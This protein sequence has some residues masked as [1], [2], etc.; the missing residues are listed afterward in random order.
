MFRL[1][2]FLTVLLWLAA[3]ALAE[4]GFLG[5]GGDVYR[6][7]QTATHDTGEADDL[8]IAGETVR[9]SAPVT[10]TA[11]VAGRWLTLKGTIGGDLYA[12][13][14][15]IRVEAPV[16][17][18]ATVA[19][20]DVT[21]GEIGGDL[22]ASGSKLALDGPVGGYALLAGEDL[23][24]GGPIGGDVHIMAR[25]VAF[26][27]DA[28][29]D[30]RLVLYEADP[31]ELEVPDH[32]APADRIERRSLSEWESELG[33]IRPPG[34][35]EIIARYLM[36]IVVVAGIAALV[37]AL[38][39]KKLADIRAQLL[40]HPARSLWYGFLSQST[41][42]GAMVVLAVSVV[43]LLVAPAMAV[44]AGLTAFAGYILGAYAFGVALLQTVGRPLPAQWS[45]RAIAGALGAAVA[46]LVALIPFVGWLFVIALTLAGVGAAVLYFL[47][48]RF[49]A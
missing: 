23:R 21:L 27:P 4:A 47:R 17:G 6:A 37:A 29:V 22:R 38:A 8:F 46:C 32:V 13:G 45:E 9:A 28:K 1:S 26:G 12:A 7:A 39:P 16:E 34:I 42:I 2:V 15:T 10:G 33:A 35:G 5:I 20:Y 40:V 49:F 14:M 41:L 48:P 19:G 44:L 25:E 11:H 36:G 18:D 31:G 3:P 24:L 30:G 43:G